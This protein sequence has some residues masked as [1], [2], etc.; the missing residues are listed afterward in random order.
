MGNKS[1]TSIISLPK[2]GGALKGIGE[3]FSPDLQTGTGNFTI[4]IALPPGRNGFQ[5]QLSLVYSSGNG[6][7]PFGLGWSLNIPGVNRKTSNGIPKYRDN[8]TNPEEL[9]TFILS[10]AEDLVLIKEE[11]NVGFKNDETHRYYKPRTEGLFAKIKHVLGNGN[12]YWE[13]HSKD[14]LVSLYGTPEAAGNDPSVVADPSN[15]TKVFSWKLSQTQDPFGNRIEY[16]YK[17]DSSN[18]GPHQWDQLYLKQIRYADYD[19]NN[20]TKFLVSVTLI[21]DDEN[22]PANHSNKRRPDPFSEYRAGFEIRTERR[23]KWML[24]K[25]HADIEHLV[26]GYEL[27][28]LDERNDLLN[29][30]ELLPLNNVSLLSQIKVVG[31]DDK[32]DSAEKLPPLEFN[33]TQFEPKKRAFFPIT[34]RD[35]PPASLGNPDYELA[36]LFG[37][38]LPDVLEMNG[39]VRYWRNL[40]DGRFDLPREMQMAPAGLRL[41]D[42][43][44][45]LIDANG[46]GRI[47]LLVT[48]EGLAGYYPIRF[49][50]LWDRRSF[51]PYKQAPSFNL[52]DPEIK[53]VDLDGDGVTDA[54][55]S[56]SQFECFFNDPKEGWNGIRL[57]ERSTLDGLSSINFSD[58]RVKWADMTGDGMQDIA[59]VHD[60]NVDY[61]PNLGYGNWGKR[62]SMRNC[63]RFPYGYNPKRILIGDVDGDGLADIVYVDNTKVTLWINQSGNSWSDPIEI[64]GTPPVSD[65]DSVRLVDML[66]TGVSGILWS[67]DAGGLSRNNMYFLNLTG[68]IKPY[69][70]NEMNNNM[71]AVTKVEYA[72][73]TKFY[74]EDEKRPRT[75]WKTP[76]PFPVQVVARVEVIDAISQGKLTT[77]YRY[78]HGYW[79]GAERE[80]RGFGM[81]EHLDT[82]IFD[83]YNK[84]GLHGE[85]MSFAEVNQLH[86]S[87]PTL[88]KTWF[89]QGP[90]GDEFGEWEETDFSGEF[91]SGDSQVLFRPQ[92]I[93]D[94]LKNLPRRIKRDALRTL[95]GSILRTELYALDGTAL[96]E[97]P[98][99]V[100]EHLY[101]VREEA[102]PGSD[103]ERMHI[104]FP[105]GLG[106]RTTQWE[107]GSEPMTQFKFTGDYDEYGQPRSQISIAVPRG[108]D[109]RVPAASAEQYLVTHTKTSYAKPNDEQQYIVDRVASITTYEIINDGTSDVFKLRD[110]IQD[111]ENTSPIIKRSVIGQ[112]LNFYDGDAFQGMPSG[113]IGKY[114]ALVRTESLVFTKEILG[115]A[116]REK[117][118]PYLVNSSWTAEYPQKFQTVLP[119]GAGYIYQQGET[120]SYYH[121]GYYAATE[122]RS[123]DFQS[124]PGGTR[125]GLVKIKRDPLGRDTTRDTTIEYDAYDLLPTRV[126]DPAGLETQAIYDY[127]VLQPNEV[128]DPNKN[129]AEFT[130]MPMGLLES[131]SIKGG[132]GEGDQ[133]RPSTRFE[134][135][136][137]AFLMERQP[138]S[139][140]SIRHVH[141]DTETDIPLPEQDE[142]IETIEYSDGFGRLLQ[143]RTQAE[144]VIFDSENPP[145]GDSG[146]PADQSKNR[147]AVGRKRAVDEPLNVIVNG[148]QIYDNK[149]HVVEKY[150]PYFSSGW[151][152]AQP[153]DDQGKKIT[154][155]YDPR[156]H[157][158]RTVNPDRSEQRVIYGIP[159]DINDPERFAPTPW[160]AYTYDANDNAGRT[161]PDKTAYQH[162]WNTPTNIMIDTLGRTIE[163][164]ERNK[165]RL[166]SDSWSPIEEYH[167]KSTYDIRGNL[168]TVTDALGRKAFQHFYDLAN[169][170][171]RVESID[172]GTKYS[173]LDA[174]GNVIEQRDSKGALI[175]H[176]YDVLNRPL[177]LWARD[178]SASPVTLRERIEY[179]DGS[180]KNQLPAERESNRTANR[181]GK[182]YKYY[183]EAGLL[184]FE[185]YDFK[186]NI[187]EKVRQVIKDEKILSA[188]DTAQANNW[189]VQ[190]YRVDWQLPSDELLSAT[191]YRISFAYDALNRI[192]WMRYPEAKD[193]NGGVKRCELQPHYNRAGALEGVK[194]DG[195]AYVEH[196]AYNAKG[197]RILI[198]YDND[199]MTRYA[200][201]E[202]TF[203]LVRMR[204]EYYKK[205]SDLTYSPDITPPRNR[206]LQEFAYEYDLNG[207]IL[208][209][210][211]KTPGCGTQSQPDRLDRTF[212]Y[213]PLNRLLEANGRQCSALPSETQ[214]NPWNTGLAGENMVQTVEY[215][216]KYEYDL[217]GN[218]ISL[219]HSA[220][221]VG[222][223]RD[224]VRDFSFIQDSN[225]IPVSNRLDKMN[226]NRSIYSYSYDDNGNLIKETASRHFEWDHSDRMKVFRTQDDGSEPTAYIQ[227]LYDSGGNRVKKLI[228]KKGGPVEVTEYIDGIF[229]YCRRFNQDGTSEKDNTLHVMD[230]QKR[231]ATVRIGK[232]TEDKTPAVK[233]HL[234]DH[235]GSSNVVIDNSGAW[236]NREEFTPYGETSFGGFARKRYRFTGKERDEES[237]LYYHGARYYAPWLGRW[238]SCD[239]CD[240]FDGINLY[241]Y[242]S[243]RPTI[244]SD[245]S[246]LT[247]EPN[248][249][250][251]VAAFEAR[252]AAFAAGKDLEA[253]MVKATMTTKSGKVKEL[254]PPAE[255]LEKMKGNSKQAKELRLKYATKQGNEASKHLLKNVTEHSQTKLFGEASQ[256]LVPEPTFH[257]GKLISVGKSPGGAPEGARNP[258]LIQTKNP[259]PPSQWEA[260][261]IGKP[262]KAVG[263]GT[264]DLKLG[265]GRIAD[266]PGV[267]EQ[268]GGLSANELRPFSRIPRRIKGGVKSVAP[269]IFQFIWDEAHEYVH[270][271]ALEIMNKNPGT[272]TL[273]DIQWMKDSGWDFKGVDDKTHLLNWEK[274]I[275]RE[276]TDRLWLF[277]HIPDI[278]MRDYM[279]RATQLY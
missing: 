15:R 55:R 44:V 85:E 201:D 130:F 203:R 259:V 31:Y 73:S 49:G 233:Y 151:K 157:V 254:P 121:Q 19:K 79:D 196:I 123:Y 172:A 81:V 140:R 236:V 101:G 119:A 122:Q 220:G 102:S 159:V 7:G 187:L 272:V 23:C 33:Y 226:I 174:S 93:A 3:T 124:D 67:A 22:Y 195:A 250:S 117:K 108:R 240:H 251:D 90:I 165:D 175:L 245:K 84:K 100:T 42:K 75:R 135:D 243:G 246:G 10:G 241:T 34:G 171:L 267:V 262:G 4:P 61:W 40:G 225:R 205:P 6:N 127:R 215:T 227:C 24:I 260:D 14:G 63:P 141:H 5:P 257:D 208:T 54:V 43:G 97:Q 156:G 238:V 88:T 161:H 111:G 115:E 129:R 185:T 242:V 50:G 217:A 144:D 261:L 1:G 41:A 169:R 223:T 8:S 275:G 46:D 239:P 70:L 231:I 9:D 160:E 248:Q 164:V 139:V 216:E 39:S 155:Y 255:N 128:I 133:S 82:E 51:Q 138:I 182:V 266:K 35:M 247:G 219:V 71:G 253:G 277:F 68:G 78:H 264:L 213:D 18:A 69:L 98:Y 230:D 58:P 57:I 271:Q 279:R 152:Y 146:L 94:F 142:T 21:Y 258:D 268:S 126:T 265:T 176:A 276:V 189:Q 104:F 134:Y 118:P 180:D 211:D 62:V 36:D 200:Y 60:G 166:S 99:T 170:S 95:R 47:D 232:F 256:K 38:G 137:N 48:I 237:G 202:N 89:H 179:G 113:K 45:Q 114:G 270:N 163:S 2:G 112:I 17:Q 76:L 269:M 199:M 207:N 234:G 29:L 64:R 235:L 83:D 72:S 273:E 167:T 209:I 106:E 120:G 218:M 59:L 229:E 274:T 80:F 153:P 244:L 53:L 178:D 96:Q 77:E 13:V 131:I 162:Y 184:T 37:N 25:T 192:K 212:I 32:G 278:L 188:F 27:I 249:V 65:M 125:R 28:Y 66:G 190:A 210:H 143:R 132:K 198:A 103:E 56:G 26:R 147:D 197:Q 87:P 224:F 204:T 221:S 86:F 183:D 30:R 193:E 194:L 173:V 74:L 145:F 252:E 116:Y 109:F 52:E 191:G 168:L 222:F 206:A 228:R 136:F 20:E 92:S 149:G 105:H 16:E 91:W 214:D 186:V 148:R 150:E 177:L 110:A 181:L 11:K 154:M 158:I 263:E 12:S 107:R